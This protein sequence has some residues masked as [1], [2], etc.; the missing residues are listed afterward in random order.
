MNEI[1]T[2][3]F[4]YVLMLSLSFIRILYRIKLEISPVPFKNN[5]SIIYMKI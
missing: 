3:V 2:M 1:F 4:I 5:Y